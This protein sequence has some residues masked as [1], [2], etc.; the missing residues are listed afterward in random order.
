[1]KCLSFGLNNRPIFLLVRAESLVYMSSL[2]KLSS[3]RWF[4][5]N[6]SNSNG[7]KIKNH[8]VPFMAKELSVVSVVNYTKNGINHFQLNYM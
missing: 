3:N 6:Y 7:L 4:R 2:S 8:S 5:F 1:M